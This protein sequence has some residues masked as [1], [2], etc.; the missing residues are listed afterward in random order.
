[1]E[2][3]ELIV[4]KQEIEKELEHLKHAIK[5]GYISKRTTIARDLLAVYGHLQHG[6]KIIDLFKIFHEHGLK[7]GHPKLAIVQFNARYCYLYKKNNGGAVFSNE[8]KRQYHVYANKSN[9]DIELPP[10][11]YEWGE[12]LEQGLRWKTVAPMVPGRVLTIAST[13]LTPQYYH[14]LFE[15]D[16]WA[17]SKP[18]TP[19]RDPILGKMLTPNIFGVIA[20]WD[21]T[22]IERTII[23]GRLKP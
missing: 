15:V 11:T 2:I 10:D 13:K 22:E 23:K 17:K 19:P 1:M 16:V 7:D 6:G 14:V 12:I 4:G 20:T 9:G 18:P 21:L 3:Q 5:E 8:N